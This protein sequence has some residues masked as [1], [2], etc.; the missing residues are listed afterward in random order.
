MYL[1]QKVLRNHSCNYCRKYVVKYQNCNQSSLISP[2]L[3]VLYKTLCRKVIF[4]FKNIG[5]FWRVSRIFN[6]ILKVL[7]HIWSL[8]TGREE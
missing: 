7:T 6:D 1:L 5:I 2:V 8:C 3:Y 4:T